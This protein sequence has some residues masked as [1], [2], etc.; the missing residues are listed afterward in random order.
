MSPNFMFLCHYPP[1]FYAKYLTT[2]EASKPTCRHV[3]TAPVPLLLFPS[4][5]AEL[6]LEEDGHWSRVMTRRKL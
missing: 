2:L 4:T 6:H 5:T 1:P 3:H